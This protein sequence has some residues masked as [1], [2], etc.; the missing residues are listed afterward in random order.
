[1]LFY[2]IFSYIYNVFFKFYSSWHTHCILHHQQHTHQ[3][4]V[5]KKILLT[6]NL[7]E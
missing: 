1:M 4:S 7:K 3:A 6:C 5:M 2:H